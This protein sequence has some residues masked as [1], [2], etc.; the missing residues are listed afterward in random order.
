MPGS[1]QMKILFAWMASLLLALCTTHTVGN[2]CVGPFALYSKVP[3]FPSTGYPTVEVPNP[4]RVFGELHY[5]STSVKVLFC[6][7]SMQESKETAHEVAGNVR[8]VIVGIIV[9]SLLVTGFW[10]FRKRNTL[11]TQK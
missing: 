1:H 3:T 7:V 5:V 6:V 9:I 4:Q 11:T 10:Y 8:I 2:Y